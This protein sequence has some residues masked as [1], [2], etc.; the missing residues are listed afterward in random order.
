MTTTA[1]DSHWAD[2]GVDEHTHYHD[3]GFGDAVTLLHGSGTGVSA[4]ANWH[5]T[6]PALS[7]RF[8]TVAPD[9]LAF[10]STRSAPDAELGI[11]AWGGQTL[12]L[13]DLLGIER[14]WL[15]GNSLGGWV[16]LQLA[17]DHPD[18]V[19]G[20]VSMGTG[21]ADRPSAQSARAALPTRETI[22][23]VL[24]AFVWDRSLI[25]DDLVGTRLAAA[26]DAE[27]R[28]QFARA[29]AARE[30][31]RR[32][33]A[34]AEQPLGSLDLPVLLIHGRE[35]AVIPPAWSWELSTLIPDA[36]LH[37]Y[38]HCGHWSQIERAVDFNR[39]VEEFMTTARPR[40][41]HERK[42]SR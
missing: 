38:P 30:R 1:L 37:I 11:R 24:E 21:G 32:Y 22:R 16:S 13:L 36:Q 29:I 7:R 41:G 40:D 26:Q 18:R 10:G 17:L 4:A 20:V 31:D 3:E 39:L 8:R 27:A 12:R 33:L 14:T 6:I 28:A 34:L 2:T 9:L 25:T 5:R 15:L 23:A 42:E 35:D 19:I